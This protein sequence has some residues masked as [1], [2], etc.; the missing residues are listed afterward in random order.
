MKIPTVR[1]T[2]SPRWSF[3]SATAAQCEFFFGMLPDDVALELS[4]S[5]IFSQTAVFFPPQTCLETVFLE[6]SG[7]DQQHA[8]GKRNIFMGVP[9]AGAIFQ[10][11]EPPRPLPGG[12]LLFFFFVFL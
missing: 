7:L 2:M 8:K 11:S 6:K 9:E 10:L 5:H 3:S 4:L 1:F 12:W